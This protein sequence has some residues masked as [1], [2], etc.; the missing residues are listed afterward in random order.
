MPCICLDAQ[1]G[2]V[3][4]KALQECDKAMQLGLPWD[5]RD[6]RFNYGPLKPT[7]AAAAL[8]S[9]NMGTHA[10]RAEAFDCGSEAAGPRQSARV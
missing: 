1:A 9:S 4:L 7:V 10:C 3:D 8:L 2:F 6:C 5:S